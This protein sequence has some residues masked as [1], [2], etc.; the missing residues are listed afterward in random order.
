MY[1]LDLTK[2]GVSEARFEHYFI[3]YEDAQNITEGYCTLSKK[4]TTHTITKCIQ[5]IL[6][7][8]YVENKDNE[9]M[10]KV[11]LSSTNRAYVKL[12]SEAIV[13]L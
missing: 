8:Y 6:T 1:W 5:N 9:N 12:Y 2:T 11:L 13:L 10:L 7:N 3:A 4:I